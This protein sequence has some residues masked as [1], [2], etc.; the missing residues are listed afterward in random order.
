MPLIGVELESLAAAAAA[1]APAAF[2]EEAL[3]LAAMFESTMEFPGT[4]AGFELA[5]FV[6]SSNTG[7]DMMAILWY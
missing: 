4:T 7:S 5:F 1:V 2:E 3:L 6:G